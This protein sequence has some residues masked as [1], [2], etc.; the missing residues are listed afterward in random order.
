MLNAGLQEFQLNELVDLSQ[1][2]MSDV[3]GGTIW[4]GVGYAIGVAAHA[5]V[6]FYGPGGGNENFV[7]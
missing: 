1:E 3:D 7:M 2:E 5:I 6:D 4:F